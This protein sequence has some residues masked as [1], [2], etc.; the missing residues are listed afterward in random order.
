MTHFRK[1]VGVAENTL[2]PTKQMEE[3]KKDEEALSSPLGGLAGILPN[4]SG[5]AAKPSATRTG[6]SISRSRITGSPGSRCD[7]PSRARSIC[8]S[9]HSSSIWMRR[10][11]KVHQGSAVEKALW[12][13]PDSAR[14][15]P[16]RGDTRGPRP[17]AAPVQV[18][19]CPFDS[20]AGMRISVTAHAMKEKRCLVRNKNVAI[21]IRA[22]L[23][24]VAGCGVARGHVDRRT[25]FLR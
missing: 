15:A 5:G 2:P 3:I 9:I 13:A 8:G 24:P 6:S 16:D 14:S 10:A 17:R 23:S 21:P 22:A 18:C 12:S 25:Y 11:G 4:A 7:Q 1:N 20:R 19:L